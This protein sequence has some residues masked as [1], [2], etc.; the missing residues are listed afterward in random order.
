MEFVIG[1]LFHVPND[2]FIPTQFVG[3][4]NERVGVGGIRIECFIDSS[5]VEVGGVG[6]LEDIDAV[7][8]L[9]E[10]TVSLLDQFC[11]SIGTVEIVEKLIARYVRY[12]R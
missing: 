9:D 8:G 6:S 5:E 1:Y 12:V 3:A 11:N 7:E 4:E 2:N 10:T